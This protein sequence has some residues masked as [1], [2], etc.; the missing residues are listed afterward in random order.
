MAPWKRV[1]AVLS[2]SLSL[3]PA[4]TSEG[5]QPRVSPAPREP[6]SLFQLHSRTA[7]THAD[8]SGNLKNFKSKHQV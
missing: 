2:K 6:A 4:L 7:H 3:L 1:L 8:C 5:S